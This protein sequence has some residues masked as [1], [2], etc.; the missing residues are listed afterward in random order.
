[1]AD[2]SFAVK[3]AATQ[4]KNQQRKKKHVNFVNAD[5]VPM[6]TLKKYFYI[7]TSG[8]FF[9]INTTSAHEV[10]KVTGGI[11]AAKIRTFSWQ[12][13][14]VLT[15]IIAV[16]VVIAIIKKGADDLLKLKLFLGIIIPIILGTLFLAGITIYTNLTSE[17][18]GPVHWHADF[19]IVQCGEELDLINPEGLSNRIG[20]PE[21]HEHGDN[22]IH[23]EGVVTKKE[24]FTLGKFFNVVNSELHNDHMV[25]STVNG[26]VRLDNNGICNDTPAE[27]Q[28]FVYQIKD[29]IVRQMKLTEPETYIISPYGTI[30]PGDCIIFELDT[31]KDKTDAI[32][33]FL[34]I[35]IDKGDVRLEK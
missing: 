8:L 22:R 30:P 31:V 10:G 29:S 6:D 1:M 13:L 17:S 35:G 11:D 20:T 12:I 3:S 25:V 27:F 15:A 23:L 19:K 21:F 24:N 4:R 18:K 28:V 2:S 34:Q 26:M 7:L 32:C 14:G 9:I 5:S 16:F 33:D